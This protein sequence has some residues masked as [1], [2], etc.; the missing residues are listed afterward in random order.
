M[1]RNPR[2]AD[3]R[4][5]PGVALLWAHTGVR[6]SAA[7]WPQRRD[8]RW[9]LRWGCAGSSSLTRTREPEGEENKWE[10]A[11]EGDD[12]DGKGKR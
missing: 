11:E 2:G 4:A 1:E 12:G 7:S 8:P 5:G 9:G 10:E 6:T 3:R